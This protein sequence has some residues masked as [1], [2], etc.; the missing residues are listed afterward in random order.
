M[1]II[2]YLLQFQHK[3]FCW[4]LN[5]ICRYIPL[6]QR[7]FNVSHSPKH[8]KFKIDKLPKIIYYEKRDN[9]DYDYYDAAGFF[10]NYPYWPL[11]I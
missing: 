11:G 3:Q 4:L 10:R 8:Q 6:K 1:D 7:G 5:S 9:K 2:L